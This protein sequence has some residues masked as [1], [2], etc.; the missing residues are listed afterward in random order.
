[1]NLST[2][3]QTE[4]RRAKALSNLGDIS[5]LLNHLHRYKSNDLF[6]KSIIDVSLQERYNKLTGLPL[7]GHTLEEK[8]KE[9][10][11]QKL[12]I[13]QSQ[14]KYEQSVTMPD[15]LVKLIAKL[16]KCEYTTSKEEVSLLLNQLKEPLPSY[17]VE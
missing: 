3:N 11:S 13:T 7:T 9:L 16:P 6:S 1:M 4:V 8:T 14:R 12:G 10:E 2:L 17:P 15:F 5:G